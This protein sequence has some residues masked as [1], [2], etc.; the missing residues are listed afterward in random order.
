MSLR[1]IARSLIATSL[2]A[3]CVVAG[4]GCSSAG[5]EDNVDNG[6]AAATQARPP[7]YVMLAF[8][9]S[10]NNEMWAETRQFAKD[11]NLHFTYFVNSV[12]Y[13]ARPHNASYKAPGHNQGLSNIG[14]GDNSADIQ[15]RLNMTKAAHAEG[16]EIGSHTAGHFDGTGWTEDQWTQE[17]DS[18]E[19]MFWAAPATAGLPAIDL[20][21]T[22]DDIKGFRAPQLGISNG[23]YTTLA[24]KGFVY[25]T[26]KTSTP[27]HWP[28]KSGGIWEF[29][30][31]Q[32]RI[33]GS[34]KSTLSMD[35]NFLYADSKGATDK[36]SANYATY[37]KQM[38][39]TYMQYFQ[40]NYFG[41]R[42]PVH[43][44]HHF[45]KWNG[46]AYWNAMKTL[47]QRVCALPEVK[48]VTYG[49]LA[50]FT[51]ENA[52][53]IADYQA[54]NFPKMARPPSEGDDVLEA[55]Q[56]IDESELPPPD[57]HEAHDDAP[58]DDADQ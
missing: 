6:A 37:Q 17:F 12:Y 16:N 25:D 27:N 47:A 33:V 51:E 7:Q 19:K 57:S 29:P 9:G 30:L 31:A 24:K 49:E 44:G 41:N 56:P 35:Y 4:T 15:T 55:V 22:Q 50:K 21:F 43:I 38:I 20:G 39:D 13:V 5:T 45:S 58:Q 2:L 34:G 52:S 53:K 14:W 1:F 8:D 28:T 10:Y 32:L 11:T 40:S 54:G 3:A 42:A 36:N 46:G 26:S 18:F 48:C 23:L